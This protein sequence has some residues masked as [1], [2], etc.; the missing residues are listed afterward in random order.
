MVQ[1]K[2]PMRVL[3]DIATS[4]TPTTLAAANCGAETSASDLENGDDASRISSIVVW[5]P[6]STQRALSFH[7]HLPTAFAAVIF[8]SQV[9]PK[10]TATQRAPGAILRGKSGV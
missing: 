9:T 4:A 2:L 5:F 3:A 6:A 8:F 7:C 10:A 1:R